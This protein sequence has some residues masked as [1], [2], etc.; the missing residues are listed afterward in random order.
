M[1]ICTP[2]LLE[3]GSNSKWLIV[4]ICFW[5]KF[6]IRVDKEKLC[7]VSYWKTLLCTKSLVL[8]KYVVAYCDVVVRMWSLRWCCANYRC[9][10]KC[11]KLCCY[12]LLEALDCNSLYAS[13][14]F[15]KQ[16]KIITVSIKTLITCSTNTHRYSLT[17]HHT[18]MHKAPHKHVDKPNNS[19]Y[20]D[21]LTYTHMLFLIHK[22]PHART[23]QQTYILT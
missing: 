6:I 17:N 14:F 12:I 20:I 15:S 21:T 4:I 11:W 1:I 7:Q 18:H 5:N 2:D 23:H 13:A 8:D 3:S 22:A 16:A 10:I 9:E 19:T